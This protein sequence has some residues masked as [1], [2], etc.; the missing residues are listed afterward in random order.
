MTGVPV[1]RLDAG[2]TRAVAELIAAAF[3]PLAVTAWLV[4]DDAK[5]RAVLADDFE[6]LVEHAMRHGVVH[7]TADRSGVAVWLP[8][9]GEPAPLPADYD[10]RVAAACGEW[11]PRFRLLDELFEAN[12]PH[13][14][15]HHLAFLAVAPGRQGRGTGTALLRHHHAALDAEGLPGYLE[16]SS[17][18]SRALYARHGY[19]PSEPFRL[20]DGTP[21]H[22]MWRAP[23]AR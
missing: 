7:G 5:R 6:I 22:P 21:F 17:D 9:V 1:E 12:H 20:P 14:P 13:A 16:A 23:A 19:V 3:E 8:Q 11:T 4:P 18:G 15:H 10:E 2:E